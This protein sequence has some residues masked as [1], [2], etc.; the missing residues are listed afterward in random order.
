MENQ[1]YGQSG[2]IEWGIRI[3]AAVRMGRQLSAVQL[4][5]LVEGNYTLNVYQGENSLDG[6]I[7]IYT[8]DYTLTGP[9]GW[10]TLEL[11]SVPTS[12]P[13]QTLWVTFCFPDNSG[14]DAP[15][16]GSPYCGN[17]DG[18]WYRFPYGWDIYR[19]IDG[20]YTWQI[21]AILN[22]NT[23]I[24]EMEDSNLKIGISGLNITVENSDGLTVRHY[25]LTDA[26]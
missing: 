18:S 7:P 17:P 23:S 16:V 15:I 3:P 14:W 10:R 6:A 2:P 13:Y 8:K 20:Y 19:P 22:S 5:F 1:L 4:F 24:D 21:R 25:D 9:Q 11:D 12:D 26:N